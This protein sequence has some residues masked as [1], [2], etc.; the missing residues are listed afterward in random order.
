MVDGI[1]VAG[2]PTLTVAA[3]EAALDAIDFI[4]AAVRGVDLIDVTD[5]LRSIWRRH[6][7]YW[8]P[9]LPQVTREWYANAQMINSALRTQ[10]PLL[11]PV[12]QAM[13]VQQW[14]MELPQMLWILD[15]VMAEAR[16][17]EV[18]RRA[19]ME[20][21]ETMRRELLKD[22]QSRTRSAEAPASAED[23]PPQA[24]AGTSS[25]MSSAA[26]IRQL[27]RQADTNVMLQ[28]HATRMNSLTIGLMQ[29]MNRR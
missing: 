28:N 20:N 21:I 15:P 27:G 10:W 1:L 14:S 3:A 24:R 29:A 18:Q 13:L 2:W 26:A 11:A 23:A 4:A 6:L 19:V 17:T 5:V 12:Q 22:I 16:R 25:D 8:Y 7:A 9:Q